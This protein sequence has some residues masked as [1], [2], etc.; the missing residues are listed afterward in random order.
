MQQEKCQ[1]SRSE[2]ERL[3]ATG[4]KGFL[5]LSLWSSASCPVVGGEGG[6][7]GGWSVHPLLACSLGVGRPVESAVHVHAQVLVVLPHLS[8][9]SQ[10]APGAGWPCGLKPITI[11][12][13]LAT[14]SSRWFLPRP[15]HQ[16]TPQCS[17]L[18][19]PL[20][21]PTTVV[22][23]ELLQVGRLRVRVSPRCL[24][25][26]WRQHCPLGFAPKKQHVIREKN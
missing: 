8:D 16:I 24:R 15:L 13:V 10:D 21:H 18:T 17:V 4:R 1:P 20:M 6:K 25:W 7:G 14:F 12:L 2:H 3:R 11:S 19:L 26:E 9:L 23:R 5:H 22:L